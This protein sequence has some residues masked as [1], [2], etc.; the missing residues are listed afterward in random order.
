MKT[1]VYFGNNNL[2]KESITVSFSENRFG[3]GQLIQDMAL[4]RLP[5]S[6][7]VNTK[8]DAKVIAI[9]GSLKT[10]NSLT[11]QD[12]VDDLGRILVSDEEHY[13]RIV[14][15]YVQLSDTTSTSGWT[16]KTNVSSVALDQ[17]DFQ[18]DK[19]SISFAQTTANA[20]AT[21]QYDFTSTNLTNYL[22]SD[23]NYELWVYIPNAYYVDNVTF[24]I[25]NDASNYY[26]AEFS[27]NY[28][29]NILTNGW[30]LLS[31]N[32]GDLTE[33]G[34]V[35]DNA[36][37]HI[38]IE[39]ENKNTPTS[40]LT[41]FKIGG[42]LIVKEDMVRNYRSYRNGRFEI[43]NNYFNIEHARFNCEFFNYT[44]YAE[45]TFY[46]EELA[47]TTS[48]GNSYIGDYNIEGT[49]VSQ[50]ELT[51][52]LN[53]A[54]SLTSIVYTNLDL[55]QSI[56]LSSTF[57]N[58]DI[59][60]FGGN[61]YR[62]LKNGSAV[63]YTGVLPFAILGTNNYQ[64]GFGISSSVNEPASAMT[65]A[66]DA[67]GG[68]FGGSTA[69]YY[70]QS[71]VCNKTG[72]ISNVRLKY[73]TLA[74]SRTLS[75]LLTTSTSGSPGTTIASTSLPVSASLQDVDIATSTSWAVTSG[76]TY[77][78]VAQIYSYSWAGGSGKINLRTCDTSAHSGVGKI[79][80]DLGAWSVAPEEM[81]FQVTQTPIASLNYDL[82]IKYKKL[83][84]N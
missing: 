47:S 70:A 71:F 2:Q 11:M 67:I 7:V 74:S 59:I 50:P 68:T 26:G 10:V 22:T 27:A 35:T 53:T 72:Y 31:I 76:T 24:R 80:V 44:G 21:L 3:S 23:Y 82:E 32:F 25:G 36:I 4:A 6:K 84:L 83:Y 49:Y 79:K 66:Y 9:N 14:Q 29:G 42:I 38:E 73:Q 57:T 54:T 1:L 62:F 63:D 20:I 78:V 19:A 51:L 69:E 13:F 65:D 41:G 52:T 37:D 15:D 17:T 43:E 45:S 64:I 39:I 16:A 33:T 12:V 61:D 77:W 5:G 58:G 48:T 46:F 81:K 60:Q 75:L 30:N 8:L 28:E 40:A 34:T 18:I 56:S 55:G